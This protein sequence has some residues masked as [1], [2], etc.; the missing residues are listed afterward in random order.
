MKDVDSVI[1]AN[2]QTSGEDNETTVQVADEK[3]EVGAVKLLNLPKVNLF[4]KKH[5]PLQKDDSISGNPKKLC[6][7]RGLM[8]IAL[9]STLIGFIILMFGLLQ[10]NGCSAGMFVI[11]KYRK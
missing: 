1:I 11:E 8:M 5:L 9:T 10:S 2:K 3:D 7:L 4:K 6:S